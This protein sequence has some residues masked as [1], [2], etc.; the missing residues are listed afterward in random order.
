MPLCG[1]A[2]VGFI[3][4]GFDRTTFLFGGAW[5]VV[6]LLVGVLRRQTSLPLG[7]SP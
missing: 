5:L 4:T 3:F 2:I 6:G 1:F 7:A